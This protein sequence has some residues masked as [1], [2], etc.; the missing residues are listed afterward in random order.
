[1][2]PLLSSGV[3]VF[4]TLNIFCTYRIAFLLLPLSRYLF[5]VNFPET[6]SDITRLKRTCSK[7]TIERLGKGVKYV[8]RK[9]KNT[10][11]RSLTSFLLLTLNMFHTFSQCFYYYFE[12]E[13]VSWETSP[14]QS[15][16]LAV[17]EVATAAC[18]S[19]YLKENFLIE[20][21]LRRKDV[22][23]DL[24]NHLNLIKA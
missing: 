16:T 21:F 2:T 10:R 19:N 12:Q 15:Y 23:Q 13:N 22:R 9:L 20:T 14:H 7:S 3:F 8:Q 24:L 1:M 17:L 4:I 18:F 6:N 11:T 5:A